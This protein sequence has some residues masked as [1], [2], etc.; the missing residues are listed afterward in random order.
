MCVASRKIFNTASWYDY[1]LAFGIG[2][3]LSYLGSL[4]VSF[5]GFFTLFLAPGA[6]F[7]IAEVIRRVTRRRRSK[8]LFQI[9][10]GSA[11]LGS[12]PLLL[13]YLL[14]LLGG[15]GLGGL[16]GILWQGF[17]AVIVTSTVYYRLGGIQI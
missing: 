11:A 6:G 1:L 4:A 7:V 2:L 8:L 13:P 15:F 5:L 12:L 16:L 9:A 14:S 10:A 3:V 17:Y